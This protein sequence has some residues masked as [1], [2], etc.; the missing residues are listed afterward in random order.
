MKIIR[1]DESV[2]FKNSESCEV[3]E[4]GLQDGAGGIAVAEIRGR[5]PE[6]GYVINDGCKEIAYILSGTGRIGW[7]RGE[8]ELAPGDAVLIREGEEYFWEGSLSIVLTSFPAWDAKQCRHLK[9]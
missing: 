8:A 5:Y 1:K 6:S 7:R 3:F 2:P 4:Y 9:D